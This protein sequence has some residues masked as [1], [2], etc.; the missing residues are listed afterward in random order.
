MN[1]DRFHFVHPSWLFVA[2]ALVVLGLFQRM[3][4]GRPGDWERAIDSGLMMA[5]ARLGALKRTAG[6]RAIPL[7]AIAASLVAISLAEPAF[8]SKSA[9]TLRNLSSLVLVIDM[10]P[11]I[12]AGGGLGDVKAAAS[13]IVSHE[14]GRPIAV[15]LFNGEA[16]IAGE[17]TTDPETPESVIAVLDAETMPHG[18]NCPEKALALARSLI[19]GSR[20][21]SADVI[22]IGGGAAL[23]EPALAEAEK[24]HA[25]GATVS[26]IHAS[27]HERAMAAGPEAEAMRRLA[28]RGGGDFS[29]AD[30]FSAASASLDRRSAR[31]L[32]TTGLAALELSSYG[33]LVLAL[34]LLPSFLML[35]RRS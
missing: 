14:A 4:A 12:I 24:L 3:R 6:A 28:G 19:A 21:A 7:A 5:M 26:T 10:S 34:V 25:M 16:Y 22:L 27:A 1:A 9:P 18:G 2:A 31:S 35:R 15:V 29:R 20:A 8:R 32:E 23:G 33:R 30:D 11:E 17:L 13:Y